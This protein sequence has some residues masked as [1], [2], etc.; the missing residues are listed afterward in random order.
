MWA[1]R[2]QVRQIN[3]KGSSQAHQISLILNTFSRYKLVSKQN[4]DKNSKRWSFIGLN[5]DKILLIT[6][7]FFHTNFFPKCIP[8]VSFQ[9]WFWFFLGETVQIT[10]HSLNVT[11]PTTKL[12]H[13]FSS[14]MGNSFYSESNIA[15][16]NSGISTLSIVKGSTLLSGTIS[17][18][19]E[20]L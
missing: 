20:K 9:Y 14:V 7:L 4:R 17:T 15:K 10:S 5:V 13:L 3:L 16:L 1:D 2:N 11:S 18:G 19:K 12:V 6:P 8:F